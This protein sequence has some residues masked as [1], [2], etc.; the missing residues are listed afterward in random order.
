MDI[1]LHSRKFIIKTLSFCV[2][3]VDLM[4]IYFLLTKE[5][6]ILVMNSNRFL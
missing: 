3:F 6:N 4:L 5:H 1:L 2:F